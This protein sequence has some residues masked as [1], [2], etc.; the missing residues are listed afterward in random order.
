MK[1]EFKLFALLLVTLISVCFWSC[2]EDDNNRIPAA[3]LP[4]DAKT[5]LSTYFP[6]I[7]VTSVE[8]NRDNGVFE[9][10][11]YLANGYEVSFNADGEWT[12]VDAPAGQSIPD[13]IAPQAITDYIAANYTGAGINDISLDSRGYEVELVSGVDLLFAPD[14]S[15]LGVDR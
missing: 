2:E 5:F 14:G 11:V 7:K 9:F 3:Q 4:S 6:S 10:D 15:F 13:G 12:D 1:K 8:L